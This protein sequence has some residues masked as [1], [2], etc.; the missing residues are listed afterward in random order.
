MRPSQK[1]QRLYTPG[2]EISHQQ[3]RPVRPVIRAGISNV[4]ST[5]RLMKHFSHLNSAVSIIE[6]YKGGQPFHSFIK[7]HFSLHKKYGS[8]DR[9]QIAHLC[10][11]YFRLGAFAKQLPVQEA[12]TAALFLC[13]HQPNELLH[14]LQPAW[15]GQAAASLPEKLAVLNMPLTA[16]GIFAFT[17]QLSEGVDAGAFAFSHLQQPDVFIR[18]RPGCLP[19]VTKKLQEAGIAFTVLGEHCIS[20]PPATKIDALLQ[21]DKEAV[22][23]DYSSQRTGAF[24]QLAATEKKPVKTW[25]CCAAS[26]GKSILATDILGHMD[27]TVT[28]IRPA[29]LANL[30]KRFRAAGISRYQSLQADLSKSGTAVTGEQFRFIIADAPCSGSG[31]WGR[32]PEQLSFFNKE[33]IDTYSQL[34]KKIVST[35]LKSLQPG[36]Y[37][38]YITCSVFKKENEDIAAFIEQLLDAPPLKMEL[39]QGYQHNADTMFAAMFRK[40]I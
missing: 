15:N 6:S 40:R 23:Q 17:D 37:F 20:L 18:V 11:C 14:A 12:V 35:A 32:T 34:Q 19:A 25:D 5:L 31:T 7:Q 28:D 30:A 29:M 4:F 3:I 27:L 16:A 39:L 1:S 8:K 33:E 22:V 26:G 10:Y 38:L 21:L 2:K 36:G 24:M 9:K 13:C